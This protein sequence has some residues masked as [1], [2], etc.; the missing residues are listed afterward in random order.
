MLSNAKIRAK[1]KNVD[2][3]LT[4]NF[5]KKIFPKN[6]KRPVTGFD[7]QFSYKNFGKRN[8]DFA[9]SLDRIIP[10][11]GYVEGN[12]I[13]VCDIANRIKS[14]STFEILEKVYKFYKKLKTTDK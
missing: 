10:E 5:L 7:F 13:F 1:K 8:K 4:L 12:V 9:P 6:N 14:N 11:R 2:F 3:N